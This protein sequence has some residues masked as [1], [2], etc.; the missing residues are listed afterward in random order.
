LGVH[1]HSGHNKSVCIHFILGIFILKEYFEDFPGGPV[2]KTLPAYVG[3][4]GS[5][6]G[7]GRS[8]MP[9]SKLRPCTT[10]RDLVHCNERSCMTMKIPHAVTKTTCSL[11]NKYLKIKKKIK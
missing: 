4:T 6:P 5:V 11:I 10:T 2:V 9:H 8:H 3:D 7:L 1:N